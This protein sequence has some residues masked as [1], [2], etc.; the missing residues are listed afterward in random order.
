MDENTGSGRNT[1]I[2]DGSRSWSYAE[3]FRRVGRLRDELESLGIG[4]GQRVAFRCPDGTGYV[5]GSLGLL[6]AGAAVVPV[7]MEL[8]EAERHET[9]ERIDVHGY[10]FQEGSEQGVDADR[11]V[12]AT[13][14]D[15]EFHWRPRSPRGHAPA[16]CDELNAA[17]IRF[18]SGT[19]GTSKGVVL[20]HD[21]IIDRT[22]AANEALR[23]SPQDRI[24]W[25]LSLSHHFVVSIL[26]YLRKGVTIVMGNRNFPVSVIE[27]VARGD[28]TFIYAS[29]VHYQ[30][31]AKTPSVGPDDLS[32]VRMAISTAMKLPEQTAAAFAAKFGIEPAE[33]Y[34]II[35][36]GLPFINLHPGPGNRGS[37]GQILPAY[38]LR[39]EDGDAQGIGEVLIRGKGMFDAYFSPWRWREDVLEDGWFRTGDL[40]RLDHEGNLYIEGREKTVIVCG[41]MKVFPVEV[42]E[43]LNAHPAVRESLVHGV[44]HP[45]YGQVPRATIVPA[46]DDVVEEELVRELREHCYSWLSPY[47][48]P[49]EFTLSDRLPRTASGKLVRH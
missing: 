7:S 29:P 4:P 2:V 21:S 32:D 23:F 28:I 24:L 27:A 9:L 43:I 25:V 13:G 46:D 17:F 15:K 31:L 18:S 34:G 36:V 26:L 11:A 12:N 3:I 1:A 47:K 49:K 6:L 37:V 33:A 45:T 35:E 19:T 22:D 16:E 39:I 48:V 38:E 20:S 44:D 5:I 14:L 10:L 41:G 40:G 8:T 42:E 30:L